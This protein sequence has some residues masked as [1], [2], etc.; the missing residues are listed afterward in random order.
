LQ[1]QA[2]KVEK[3][4]EILQITSIGIIAVILIVV[5]KAH[6]PEIAIQVSLITGVVIFLLISSKLYVILDLLESLSHK[7]GI[8]SVYFITLLKIIGIS[9]IAEFGSEVCRDAGE[10][11]IASKIEL[12]GKVIIVV[13]AVPIMTSLIDLISRIM[14]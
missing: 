6:K 7:S 5:L 4:L 3:L 1:K 10:S 11:S 13:L 14:P 8:D 12:A 9:Y 2:A